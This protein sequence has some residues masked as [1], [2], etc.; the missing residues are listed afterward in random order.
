MAAFFSFTRKQFHIHLA[1]WIGY[2]L[3]IFYGPVTFMPLHSAVLFAIRSLLL[4][5]AIFYANTFWL[6]PVYWFKSKFAP[7]LFWAVVLIGSSAA[8]SYSTEK[9]IFPGRMAHRQAHAEWPTNRQERAE[10]AAT[11]NPAP[12]PNAKMMPFHLPPMV[13]NALLS[14]LGMILISSLLAYF[15]RQKSMEQ[16]QWHLTNENLAFE[17]KFL[18][19]QINPHFLFNALN[20]VYAL[21][22]IRS[23]TTPEMILK[24][25]DMLRYT[26]YESEAG[27]VTLKKELDYI[28]NFI[29]FQKLK[30][31]TEPNLTVQVAQCNPEIGIEPMLL[32]P[33]VENSFKH[34]HIENTKK[35][36]IKLEIK[37][38]GPIL[39]FHISNSV[40]P[41]SAQP[42]SGGIGMENVRKR[43]ELF[44]PNKYEL[45]V[46]H[47][48][49]EHTVKLKIDTG[50]IIP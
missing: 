28:R 9:F 27:K 16:R 8:L 10:W 1:L 13:I 26:L 50:H 43:L 41:Q 30:L 42:P 39:F 12:P 14:S 5:A 36:W 37:T 4:N 32:I 46:H 20:N 7:Y 48:A 44:Y 25:S 35:G 18:K 23:A 31:D 19:S 22:V 29:D 2:T 38:L 6:L 17:M 24:L 40:L 47:S 49:H 34:G 33:F 45:V 3:L 11:S 15:N 21:S